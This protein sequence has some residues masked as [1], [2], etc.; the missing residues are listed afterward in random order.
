MCAATI[1]LE[2]PRAGAD[3]ETK[4]S[5]VKEVVE[6]ALEDEIDDD[7]TVFDRRSETTTVVATTKRIDIPMC[8]DPGIAIESSRSALHERPDL[9]SMLIHRLIEM[10]D[11]YRASG[12]FRQATEIY[13]SII[14]E[15]ADSVEAE[16]AQDRLFDIGRTYE[17]NG[18]LRLA[19]GIYERLL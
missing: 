10:A 11:S 1:E 7:S 19:R 5:A 17:R 6:I 14:A 3:I 2:M 18:E 13:F 4:A 9:R 16:I 8:I 15:H 12:S